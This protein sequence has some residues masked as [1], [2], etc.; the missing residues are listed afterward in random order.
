MPNNKSLK[1]QLKEKEELVAT[2][3]KRL[4]LAA[5]QLD[6]FQRSGADK[7]VRSTGG[8]FSPE[9]IERQES[10]VE[11]LQQAV[12]QWN[13]IQAGVTLGNLAMQVSELHNLVSS[14]A[15]GPGQPTW[16]D[17]LIQTDDARSEQSGGKVESM[18]N[19]G[20]ADDQ[21]ERW[22]SLKSH[23]METDEERLGTAAQRDNEETV[24]T[25]N[26]NV[27][28]E[29]P[30]TDPRETANPPQ[31][32]AEDEEDVAV[33]RSAVSARDEYIE[34]L[35][36]KLRNASP[37]THLP[38]DWTEWEASPEELCRQVEDLQS[39][40]TETLRLS[41]LEHSLERARLG[42]E[43]SR[44]RQM[45]ETARK[46]LRQ[47]GL[48][49]DFDND[50]EVELARDGGTG[51]RWLRMLGICNDDEDGFDEE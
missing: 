8:G 18:D 51:N 50:E 1:S 22:E 49:P 4:E 31:P 13:E 39:Q 40:L 12:Q 30:A 29:Q 17:S 16:Q 34:F 24:N 33:L 20:L 9:L 25:D 36:R 38:T 32:I 2:L 43:E 21:E 6:R 28:S 41:E 26:A 19:D 45:E 48:D 37:T 5:E 3:T 10:L 35:I 47:L 7:N 46:T 14:N 44:V 27:D 11:D 23:L 15:S 42:R